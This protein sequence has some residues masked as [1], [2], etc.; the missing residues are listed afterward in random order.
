MVGFEDNTGWQTKKK[1][2]V[3]RIYD[4]EDGEVLENNL[5]IMDVFSGRSQSGACGIDM[6]GRES[7]GEI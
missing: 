5:G 3:D 1:K 6:S 7:K 4:S 2:A